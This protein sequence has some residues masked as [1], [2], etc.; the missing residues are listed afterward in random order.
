MK[1]TFIRKAIILLLALVVLSLVALA[2][3]F[4]ALRGAS[5]TLA[6][7]DTQRLK[8]IQIATELRQS[9]DDLTR[10]ARLAVTTGLEEYERQYNEVLDIRNG[11]K[12][13]P[14]DYHLI[15]WDLIDPASPTKPRPD[16][17]EFVPLRQRMQQIGFTPAELEKLT[18]A[19]NKSNVLAQKELVAMNMVK[20]KYRN[21][22]GQFLRLDVPNREGAIKMLSDVDY[23]REKAEVMKPLLAFFQMMETRVGDLANSARLKL[24]NAELLF[25]ALIVVT[26]S[27]IG[28]LIY[29]GLRQSRMELAERQAAQQK[30]EAENES[31]NNSVISILQAVSQISQRDLTA[32]APVTQDIIGTVS[33]SINLL[34][35]ETAKVLHGVTGIA[36]QVEEVSN[37]VKIQADQVSKTAEQERHSVAQMIESLF[38]ATQTMNQVAALAEQSNRSAE[39]ATQ[40]TDNALETVT[41]TVKGM[42]SI[43]ETIAETEKRI[44]RLG[45]RS[46]EISGIVNLI[47]T[48]SERTHVLALNASMQAAVAGEAGRGFAVVA[49]EVQRLAESSR[50]ATQQIASLVNNI[51]IETNETINTVNRTIGQVVQGSEQAQKA[52]EQMRRTQQITSQLVAQVGRIAESSEQQKT[53]SANLLEAVQEIGKSTENTAEQINTQ[54]LQ[55]DTLLIAARQLVE[56]VGV[57]KLPQAV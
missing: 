43:R 31:L 20:G 9:S 30:A 2:Y 28:A 1:A 5:A 18:D 36:G 34:T 3:A 45:E 39:Q 46:Q 53:M 8:S 23:Q 29:F 44:K 51:Q 14:Q 40:I 10:M 38:E 54:N 16:T 27:L 47:N 11:A 41:G 12:A 50:N 52:G 49:E 17:D 21:A 24:N 6:E 32:K 4:F 55:T 37:Q 42:E 56:S 57:F 48:I 13:R 7:A 22:Q 25:V 19:E 26:L 15:Y 35:D 33:D